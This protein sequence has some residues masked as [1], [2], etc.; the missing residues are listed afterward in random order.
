MTGLGDC[1]PVAARIA[2]ATGATLCHGRPIGTGGE[3]A[4][5]RYDHAWVE[6]DHPVDRDAS[7]VIDQS[8]G[9]NIQCRRSTY[10]E[11]GSIDPADVA[12][13]TPEEAARNMVTTGHY[14]P[15]EKDS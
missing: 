1:F 4:G 15:W 5:V 12:R 8:N 3:V 9:L 2:E 11:L 6:F 7:L 13:Y 10:Y 14:G